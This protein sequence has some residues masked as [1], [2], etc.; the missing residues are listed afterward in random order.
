MKV[1][2]ETIHFIQNL[3]PT[4]FKAININVKVKKNK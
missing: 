2:K 3:Y 1:K 4:I